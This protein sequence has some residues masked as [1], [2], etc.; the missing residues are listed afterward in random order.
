[1][2]C[3]FLVTL[4]AP[5]I[6]TIQIGVDLGTIAQVVSDRCVDLFLAQGG[7][8]RADFLRRIALLIQVQ[9]VINANPMSLD[10][11]VICAQKIEIL[12]QIH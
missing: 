12:Q 4:F 10:T 11:D 3:P 7:K 8:L 5:G 9:N 2:G 6:Q 1:M